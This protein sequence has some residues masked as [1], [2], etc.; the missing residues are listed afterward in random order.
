MPV[1]GSRAEK[2]VEQGMGFGVAGEILVDRDFGEIG[3]EHVGAR[4]EH[5]RNQ[6][7][8]NLHPIGTQIGQ[9]ALHQPAVVCLA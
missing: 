3:A 5:D 9:Q 1:S 2:A 7:D 4:L 8:H 6:G